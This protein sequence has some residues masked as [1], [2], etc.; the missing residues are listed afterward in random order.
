M[1]ERT[2]R[3]EA[4]EILR[5]E[6]EKG[7]RQLK[8]LRALYLYFYIASGIL[9][10]L[11]LLWLQLGVDDEYSVPVFG[12]IVSIGCGTFIRYKYMSIGLAVVD[13]QEQERMRALEKQKKQ[14][15][16]DKAIF[17][18]TWKFPVEKFYRE[19][20]KANA[21]QMDNEFS[22]RKVRQNAEMLIREVSPNINFDKCGHYLDLEQL[23]KFLDAGSKLAG[24]ADVRLLAAQ[25]TPRSASPSN[26]E[27]TFIRRADSVSRLKGNQ[28]R[29]KMLSDLIQDFNKRIEEIKEGEEAMK[30]LGMLYMQQQKKEGDWAIAGGIADGLAGPVA[31]FMAASQV[32]ENNREIQRHN[33][34]MRN[35]SREI[36]SGVVKTSQNRYAIES[37][38]EQAEERCKEAKEKISLSTPDN[39]EIWN[40]IRVGRY[41]IKKA[42]SGV[43]H[44]SLPV[45]IETPFVLDVP[46][47]VNTVV[48]GTLKAEVRFEDKLVGT[49][50]F[51][52][53]L[54]G[55]PTNMT[56]E[57]TLDGMLDR[58]VEFNGEY[59][60]KML[61]S[62]N[63]W[64][65]E[66]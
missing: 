52:L 49:V 7:N 39:V 3:A 61:D 57:V 25:K 26:G 35:T 27:K 48:D 63:L 31:G 54:Y 38:K 9:L 44:I 36:L 11:L 34:T 28:K 15:A 33:E 23:S 19:C 56:A 14:D 59:T 21:I 58:S 8:I 47:N 12:L 51:P 32:M 53:P 40:H 43:L 1:D 2:R 46:E 42:E 10:F 64:I 18:G 60:L 6:R 37:Q 45:H 30:T 66:A 55:I 29:V 4:K 50:N 16:I 65:M 62:H 22:R 20:K 13:Q 41:Q 24:E 5:K 17:D